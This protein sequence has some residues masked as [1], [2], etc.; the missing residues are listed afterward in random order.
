MG[1]GSFFLMQINGGT[2]LEKA[3]RGQISSSVPKQSPRRP[4][5]PPPPARGCAGSP[6]SSSLQTGAPKPPQN[7][8]GRRS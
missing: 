7:E 6:V 4:A 8:V 3:E 2:L 5:S 1:G